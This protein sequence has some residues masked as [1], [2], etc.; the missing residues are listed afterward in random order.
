MSIKKY[1]C[2]D[3]HL[4]I[5]SADRLRTPINFS[6][7]IFRLY[8]TNVFNNVIFLTN[9]EIAIQMYTLKL[10]TGRSISLKYLIG[11]SSN[12]KADL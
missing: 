3:D 2:L 12:D 1:K 10:V 6:N 8:R 7:D 4:C 9:G 5:R 11:G